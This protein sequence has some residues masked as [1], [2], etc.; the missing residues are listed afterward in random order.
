MVI[1]KI[2]NKIN[3]KIY[4]GQTQRNFEQRILEHVRE[5]NRG[6]G[7]YLHCAIR[8]Y[9]WDNFEAE[10]IAE[11]ENIDTLNELEQFYIRKYRSDSIGYNLAPGGY[12]NCMSSDEVKAHHD[13]VMRSPE[14]RAKI[15]ASMK[16]RIAADGGVSEEHRRKVS[17][18][19]RR[20]Y[21]SGKKPNY[22]QPQHLSPEHYRALNDAKNK[23]VY[24]IDSCN[25]VVAEFRRVK[26]AADWWYHQ[27]YIV[28]DVNQL[29]DRIKESSKKD[30]YIRGL[31]WIYRV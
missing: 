4:I 19:L 31:K 12:S 7:Y 3:G 14:V 24:C 22:K 21:A 17:E 25:N 28:K 1:Y 16:A 5:A 30:K 20:F 13:K 18:G 11:T 27:G 23:A 10:I 9:G 29:C 15:S 6:E 8:K 26:D 2:T